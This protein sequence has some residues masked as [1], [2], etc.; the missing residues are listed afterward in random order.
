MK[1]ND[2]KFI[3]GNQRILRSS[4]REQFGMN[5]VIFLQSIF[6]TGTLAHLAKECAY[7][8]RTEMVAWEGGWKTNADWIERMQPKH[9]TKVMLC[10]I[11]V[12]SARVLVKFKEQVGA[13]RK[14]DMFLGDYIVDYSQPCI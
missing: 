10:E 12:A 7:R 11:I 2:L 4:L 1:E 13:L 8:K 5:P 9:C 6:W 14:G 3:Q